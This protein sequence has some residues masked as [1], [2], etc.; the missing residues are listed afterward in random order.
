VV[1]V[2][3]VEEV[4]V[5]VG[6][7]EAG[8]TIESALTKSKNKMRGSSDSTILFWEYLKRKDGSFGQH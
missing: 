3:S 1:V 5:V 4:E 7:V 8:K 6:E 2:D